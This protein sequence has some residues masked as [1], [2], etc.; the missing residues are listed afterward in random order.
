[1]FELMRTKQGIDQIV[2]YPREEFDFF[3]M[4]SYWNNNN[5]SED[6]AGIIINASNLQMR[7]E[8]L[9]QRIYLLRAVF[10]ESLTGALFIK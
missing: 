2:S 10:Q 9:S 4:I 1:M 8:S 6:P 3:L 5:H 7:A